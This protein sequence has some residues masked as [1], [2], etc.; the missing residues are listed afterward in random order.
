MKNA[1][2]SKS[3]GLD[4]DKCVI[5]GLLHDISVVVKP[6]DML[7]YANENNFNICEA[8]IKYPF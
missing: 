8:E 3:Y 2:I 4:R 1:L 5:A 7:K 6:E